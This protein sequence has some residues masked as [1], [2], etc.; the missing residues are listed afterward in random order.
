MCYHLGRLLDFKTILTPWM[1]NL[2]LK[3][4]QSHYL[5]MF[6]VKFRFFH[7]ILEDKLQI[8]ELLRI[9]IFKGVSLAETNISK[10]FL[11]VF[12]FQFKPVYI[13]LLQ[14]HYQPH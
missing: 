12:I 13:N 11:P 4:N 2:L 14:T 3:V 8:L 6:G 7:E 5:A 9:S 10:V 1:Q